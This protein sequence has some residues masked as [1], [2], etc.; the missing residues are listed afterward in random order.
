MSPS[1][2]LTAA[3]R[4]ALLLADLREAFGVHAGR[5]GLFAPLL[6]LIAGWLDRHVRRFRRIAERLHAGKPAPRPRVR[7]RLIV[8]RGILPSRPRP[9]VALPR[10]VRWLA[11][12]IGVPS[13]AFATELGSLVGNPETLA[14]LLAD[15]PEMAPSLRSLCRS[16]GVPVPKTLR[17]FR[18]TPPSQISGHPRT[19]SG[20][21]PPVRREQTEADREALRAKIRADT[22]EAYRQAA[23]ARAAREARASAPPPQ[24]PPPP[25]PAPYT[26]DYS[27][28]F[29]PMNAAQMQARSQAWARRNRWR[30][31]E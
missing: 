4:I 31:R 18:R 16:L 6:A 26:G 7:R 29:D 15:A 9:E 12:L 14:A 8:P 25:Q 3:D 20:D 24:P 17:R 21:P 23:E 1:P 28:I 2:A 11:G 13:G 30:W 19:C 27:H 10:T 22:E 5:A